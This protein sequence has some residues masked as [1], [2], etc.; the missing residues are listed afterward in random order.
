MVET[1]EEKLARFKK[2]VEVDYDATDDLREAC[3]EDMRF[4]NVIGGMWEGWL[5]HTHGENGNRARMEFD[6]ISDYKSSY[7]GEWMLNRANV[8]YEPGDDKTSEDDAELLNGVYRADFND[9]DGQISQDNAVDEMAECGI[10]AFK[11]STKF[12]DEDDPEN[13]NQD[14]IFSPVYNAYSH[15]IWEANAKRIDKADA[16]VCTELT[17][18]TKDAF[19]DTFPDAEPIS[20]YEPDTR[21][22]G[23]TWNT[24]EL[25][26]VAS[27]Y[28]VKK[29]KLTVHVYENLELGQVQAYE[30]K[31]IDLIKDELADEGWEYV[32]ERVLERN[33]VYKSIFNGS[34]LIEDEKLIAG[35]FIPIIPMYGYRKFIDGI[36]HVF[37]LVRK[38]KD[39]NRL[40]NANISRMAESGASSGDSVP[41][42]TE[43]QITGKEHLWADRTTGAYRVLN[44]LEDAEGNP[45]PSQPIGWDQPNQVDPN[46]IATTDLVSNYVD[47]RTGQN[48]ED[49]ADHRGSEGSLREI[50]KKIN[51][52]TQI[53][54]DNIITAIKHSG[55]VYRAILAD[56]NTGARTKRTLAE[57]GT[58]SIAKLNNHIMDEETGQFVVGNDL[59]KGKFAVNVKVGPQYETQKEAAMDT[60]ERIIEKV[61]QVAPDYIPPLIASWVANIDGPGLDPLKKFNRNKQLLSGLI[62]PETDEE[63]AMLQAAG[64]QTN[65]Q[66]ELAA[67]ATEQQKADAKNLAASAENKQADTKKKE[68]ETEEILAGL[69]GKRLEQ[70]DKVVD[71]SQK[72]AQNMMQR[73][74]N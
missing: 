62:E 31:D 37:G 43:K 5:E 50:K 34:A 18:Y 25:I 2:Q 32:R 73:F 41:I 61:A 57:D 63:Q 36:E 16:R 45:I 6:I 60:I 72:R 55:N 71:I 8:T 64:Q 40:I 11:L 14:I 52:N 38:L 48:R 56:I 30:A 19:S 12:E 47:K 3:N 42:F 70:V 66:D 21:Y 15:V 1:P 10:G 22:R 39:A 28:E 65:P 69:P 7:V 74:A 49:I 33:R 58:A 24:P 26:T 35:R 53:L 67:A 54:S 13:D 68:A 20:A 17:T 9:N 27:R 4:C 44:D 59:S 46:T 51:L 29:E 23:F